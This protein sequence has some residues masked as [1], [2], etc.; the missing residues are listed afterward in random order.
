MLKNFNQTDVDHIY[1]KLNMTEA[2]AQLIN[3]YGLSKYENHIRYDDWDDE[4][5]YLICDFCYLLI[6]T[7]LDQ[8]QK[9]IITRTTRKNIE[10]S[11][12]TAL[13]KIKYFKNGKEPGRFNLLIYLVQWI[14]GIKEYDGTKDDNSNR[15][16]FLL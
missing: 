1:Y 6:E 5:E 11:R 4:D 13:I 10:S 8:G 3:I 2:R 12:S 9:R 14:L 16:Y 15:T 7:F